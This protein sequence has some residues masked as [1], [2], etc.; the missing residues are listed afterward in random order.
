MMSENNSGKQKRNVNQADYGTRCVRCDLRC[1]AAMAKLLKYN[2]KRHVYFNIP[3]EPKETKEKPRPEFAERRA[4]KSLKQQWFLKAL[5]W[6]AV[7]RANDSRYKERTNIV[8]GSLH[9]HNDIFDLWQWDNRGKVTL[10]DSIPAAMAT[11]LS[12]AH[13]CTFTSTD[14]FL[15]NTY[16]PLPNVKPET[17]IAYADD[18]ERGA[19]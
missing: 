11:D 10:E 18:L 2:P 6:N 12:R 8:F 1:D 17:F 7:V 15:D 9:V 5:P 19:L 13:G 14:K 3:K 4:R 16:V